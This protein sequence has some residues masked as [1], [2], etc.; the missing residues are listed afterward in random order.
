[1]LDF[2]LLV[3]GI[4]GLWFGSEIL[5]KGAMSLA[6][7]YSL[8]DALFGMVV[9]AIGTDLP[10]LFVAF[11]ASFRSLAG[12]D[13]S[14]IV[15]GSAIGSAIAQ[16]ALVFGVVG[17]IGY[18][19]MQQKFLSRNAFFLVGGIVAVFLFSMDGRISRLEGGLLV[20]YYAVYLTVLILRR[21]EIDDDSKEVAHMPAWRACFSLAC[22]LSILLVSAKLTVV[23]AAEFATDAGLSNIAVSAIVIGLGSSLPELSVSFVALM[24]KRGGLSVGNLVGSNVLDTLL[25]PGIAAIISPLVVSSSILFIDLPVLMLSTILILLFFYVTRR[26]VRKPEAVMLLLVYFSYAVVRLGGPE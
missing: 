14:G 13:L 4:A 10:E 25:V 23:Y 2:L 3:C 17:F 1:M 24:H 15:I 7:R 12:E 5:I 20:L 11:D 18:P 22:G 16:F 8:S 19:P 26:G 6:D 21:V 9:L